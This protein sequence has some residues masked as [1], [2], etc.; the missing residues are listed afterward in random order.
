MSESP[1]GVTMLG[2]DEINAALKS[3]EHK[4]RKKVLKKAMANAAADIRKRVRGATPKG[5]T[6]N[7]RKS[8]TSGSRILRKNETIW[9]GVWYSV[10]GKKKG[11]HANWIEYGTNERWV[12]NYRGHDGV[13]VSVGS[14]KGERLITKVYKQSMGK[15]VKTFEQ[16]LKKHIDKVKSAN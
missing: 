7:L 15:Q 13:A 2:M 8:V 4:T 5:K 6:G 14:I 1:S 9:G 12:Q 16:F 10:K 3:F 11:F